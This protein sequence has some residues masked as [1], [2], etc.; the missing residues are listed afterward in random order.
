MLK[1]YVLI[2]LLAANQL[3]AT[4]I[5]QEKTPPAKSG[6]TETQQI[7]LGCV[8]IGIIGVV[9]ISLL[10]KKVR[11]LIETV[12]NSVPYQ[13]ALISLFFLNTSKQDKEEKET[14][15][16]NQSAAEKEPLLTAS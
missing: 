13:V 12:V 3:A 15:R 5:K 9:T 16:Q 8:G 14:Q 2:L 6:L 4:T 10:P 11:N 7:V 1:K